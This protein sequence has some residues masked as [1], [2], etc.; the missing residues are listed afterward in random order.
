MVE[1]VFSL[2]RKN[3]K[4]AGQGKNIESVFL[5]TKEFLLM[6]LRNGLKK[7]YQN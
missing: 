2:S 4:Y 7:T 6:L 1:R 3:V 5:T